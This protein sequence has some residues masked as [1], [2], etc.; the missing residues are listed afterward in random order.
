ML[1]VFYAAIAE[2]KSELVLGSKKKVKAESIGED[3]TDDIY[4]LEEEYDL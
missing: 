4:D 3:I 2:N 1:T